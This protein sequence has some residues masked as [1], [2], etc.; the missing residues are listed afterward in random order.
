MNSRRE[1]VRLVRHCQATVALSFDTRRLTGR[2]VPDGAGCSRCSGPSLRV[3]TDD[4]DRPRRLARAIREAIEGSELKPADL[5][6]LPGLGVSEKTVYRWMNGEAVPDV[7]QLRPLADALGVSPMMFVD[8]PVPPVYPLADY[9]TGMP[10]TP[11]EL[12]AAAAEHGTHDQAEGV[13]R[14]RLAAVP[15]AEPPRTRPTRTPR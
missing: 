9:R 7:L 12:A 15:P 4:S 3:V 8:P 13:E 2:P 14:P 11:G 10:M 6:R 5:G 1:S